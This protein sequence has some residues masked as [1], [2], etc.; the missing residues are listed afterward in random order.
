MTTYLYTCHLADLGDGVLV[1]VTQVGGCGAN[2][3]RLI[4]LTTTQDKTRVKQSQSE[5]QE[6]TVGPALTTGVVLHMCNCCST[7]HSITTDSRD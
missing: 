4:R 1:E 6:V 2:V 5:L 7:S 3:V